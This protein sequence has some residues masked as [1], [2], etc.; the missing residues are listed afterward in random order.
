M[1]SQT[2]RSAQGQQYSQLAVRLHWIVAFLVGLQFLLKGAMVSTMSAIRADQTPPTADYLLANL[3]VLSGLTIAGLMVWRLNLRLQRL[4]R[5]KPTEA[6]TDNQQQ[7]AGQAADKAAGDSS[8]ASRWRDMF[9]PLATGVHWAFYVLLLLLPLTGLLAYYEVSLAASVHR[10]CQRLLLLLLF[11][12]I[13]AALIHHFL[14]RDNA[15]GR[16]TGKS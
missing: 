14:F 1:N 2:A 5:A 3:H 7:P 6:G 13:L 12:H 10:G 4:R 16:I 11:M 15:L 9:I 8:P